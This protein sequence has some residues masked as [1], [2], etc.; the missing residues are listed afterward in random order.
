M[1]GNRHA[2]DDAVPVCA[3]ALVQLPHGPRTFVSRVN[4]GDRKASR[5]MA[6]SMQFDT[7]KCTINQ[8]FAGL[9]AS[10]MCWA[11]MFQR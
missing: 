8:A 4:R 7:N 2:R 9:A 3:G 10:K 1:S 6:G 5:M 11:G